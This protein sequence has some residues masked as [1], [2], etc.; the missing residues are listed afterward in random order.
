MGRHMHGTCTYARPLFK[1]AVKFTKLKQPRGSITI[2][3]TTIDIVQV[4]RVHLVQQ[5]EHPASAALVRKYHHCI[6]TVLLIFSKHSGSF[7]LAKVG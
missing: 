3:I 7:I 5:C 4:A 1:L 6:I 2:S